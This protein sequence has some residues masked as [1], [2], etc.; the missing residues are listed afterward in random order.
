[1]K[2]AMTGGSGFIGAPLVRRLLKDGHSVRFLSRSKPKKETPENP[3]LTFV[4]AD[5][6]DENAELENFIGDADILFHC[7]GELT[8]ENDMMALHVEGTQRLIDV[9]RGRVAH[10][11]QLS[12][13]GAYGPHQTGIVSED[14]VEAPVGIYET[15]KTQS[16]ELVRKAAQD[17]AF[18]LTVLRPANVI[19]AAMPNQSVFQMI[20]AI[21][22]GMFAYIGRSGA[23]TNYVSVDNVMDALILCATRESD[24]TEVYNLAQPLPLEEFV[25]AICAG[26]NKPAPTLR[27][28]EIPMRLAAW[29]L[30]VIPGF[31]LTLSRVDALTSRACYSSAKIKNHLGYA[32]KIPITDCV[33]QMARAWKSNHEPA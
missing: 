10:W 7:A 31:P 25:E 9:A 11:V 29:M 22:R 4:R 2:A 3:N 19:G 14:T 6:R 17:G 15:S 8:Q 13:V 23:M 26:L 12:S 5:L 16:D 20:N 33:S 18:K 32:P 28:P 24:Q 21:D 30:G 27:L 1:M